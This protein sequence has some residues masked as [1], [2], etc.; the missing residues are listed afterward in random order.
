MEVDDF[1][2]RPS[3]QVLALAA[4]ECIA[5][6]LCI[7]SGHIQGAWV[8][9]VLLPVSLVLAANWLYARGW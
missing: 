6:G 4:W 1:I 5:F 2:V 7:A 8:A 3:Y 9:L